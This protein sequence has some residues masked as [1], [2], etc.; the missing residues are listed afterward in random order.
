MSQPTN[1]NGTDPAKDEF[2]S[3]YA[4][5]PPSIKRFLFKFIPLLI[6][7]VLVFAIALPTVHD[8]FN[9]GR[10]RGGTL[11]GFLAADPVPHILV[12]RPGKTE[13]GAIQ[14]SRYPLSGTNKAGPR[15][16]ILKH[17]GQWV[18]LRGAV[19]HRDHFT[20][21]AAAR[22]EP[23]EAPIDTP[24]D[25]KKGNSLGEF[26]LTGEILDGKCYPGIMKP[27]QGKTHRACAIRC[28]AGGVPAVFRVHNA[29][30]AVMYFLLADSQGK[31][32][33]DQILDMVADPIRIT[34]T[35][36]QYDD[37]YVLQADPDTY[38][39]QA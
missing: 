37:M 25:P 35:V 1:S 29:Q 11:E 36:M 20:M 6:V 14:F 17:L 22:A 30:N 10:F 24:V 39:R 19:V 2:Y 5:L 34:G 33:N 4:P 7:G 3:G 23:I 27:G 28:I 12:P 13:S 26:S 9:L 15:K 16:A 38:E 18:E 31:A 21:V 32:V 8:Q